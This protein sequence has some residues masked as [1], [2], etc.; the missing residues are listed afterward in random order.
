M[1]PPPRRAHAHM[2]RLIQTA[3]NGTQQRQTC[4]HWIQLTGRA[5]IIPVIA[6]PNRLRSNKKCLQRQL[7]ANVDLYPMR[8]RA[9]ANSRGDCRNTD[10]IKPKG[11][12]TSA[13]NPVNTINGE[14]E[15]NTRLLSLLRY[16]V[17]FA[18]PSHQ[19]KG[20]CNAQAVSKRKIRGK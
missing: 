7:P 14:T 2:Q 4:Q 10:G 6:L 19:K 16:P 13:S 15:P 5:A 9:L 20:E 11:E 8:F 3:A 1:P 18:M 12:K 17:R